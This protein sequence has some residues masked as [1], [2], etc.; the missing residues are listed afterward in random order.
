MTRSNGRLGR[1]YNRLGPRMGGMGLAVPAAKHPPNR[2]GDPKGYNTAR[3]PNSQKVNNVVSSLGYTISIDPKKT[4]GRFQRDYNLVH[5]YVP[6]Q[7]PGTLKPD[8]IPGI[9][10]LNG[11]EWASHYGKIMPKPWMH[12]V[13][14]FRYIE[15]QSKPK[16]KPPTGRRKPGNR[17]PKRA[18]RRRRSRR[19]SG[20]CPDGQ[21]FDAVKGKCIADIFAP[22]PKPKP[23]SSSGRRVRGAGSRAGRRAGRKLRRR[24]R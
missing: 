15:S 9:H 16:P 5:K 1:K 24:S 2:S 20:M 3:F 14:K 21:I 6:T 8:G 18:S 4:F 12:Y 7:I 17:K 10:T 11:L 22:A 23:A 19:Y 13:K